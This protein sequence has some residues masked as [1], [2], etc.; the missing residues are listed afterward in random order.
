MTWGECK[1]ATMQKMFTSEDEGAED[2][3][4]AMPQAA[5]EAI[6]MIAT[7]DAGRHIRAH[8]I[9]TKAPSQSRTFDLETDLIDFLDVGNFETYCMDGEE[10][11]QVSLKLLGGHLLVVP[12][13]I[14][15]VLVFYN[16][17]PAR[18]TAN[19]PDAQEINLPEDA[20]ALLP[21]YMAS[22]LYKDDDLAIATTY[23][24]EFETAFERL[25]N[26]QAENIETEFT[27]ESGWW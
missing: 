8:D 22:Q 16:A 15:S 17:K 6:Q 12:K 4:A 5:N 14:G 10:P 13:G 11:R 1:T 27:S 25:K 7:T 21:M 19:T 20:A 23:R 9:L 24:N 3:L 26:R 2:Y 18:I